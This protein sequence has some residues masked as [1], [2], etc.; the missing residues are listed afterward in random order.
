MAELYRAAEESGATP[1][2]FQGFTVASCSSGLKINAYVEVGRMAHSAPRK[3]FTQTTLPK[4]ENL[5]FRIEGRSIT[6]CMNKAF[7]HIENNPGLYS[8]TEVWDSE[9]PE[10]V[11]VVEV[12]REVDR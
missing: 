4:C 11:Y 6:E 12:L 5:G 3:P 8:I 1:L 2:Y 9:L 7:S 10:N